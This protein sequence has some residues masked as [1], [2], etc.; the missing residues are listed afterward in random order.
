MTPG[1]ANWNGISGTISGNFMGGHGSVTF[2]IVGTPD[3]QVG[4]LFTPAFGGTTAA[5][6]LGFGVGPVFSNAQTISDFNGWFAAMGGSV[7][8]GSVD[9]AQGHATDGRNIVVVTP[10]VGVNPEVSFAGIVP[11]P[12]EFHGEASYTWSEVA[13][14]TAPSGSSTT[15][16]S[17]SNPPGWDMLDPTADLPTYADLVTEPAG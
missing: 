6:G 8:V 12:A 13:V 1:A 7:P 3:G 9:V 2:S 14:D 15:D 5:V 10:E 11:L 4:G 17:T 16:V